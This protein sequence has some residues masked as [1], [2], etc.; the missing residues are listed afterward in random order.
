VLIDGE[1][2]RRVDV[3]VGIETQD[4]IEIEEGLEEGQVIE[5]P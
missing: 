2:R 3:K 1:T 5:G 4:R